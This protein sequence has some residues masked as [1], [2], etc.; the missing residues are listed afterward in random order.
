[1]ARGRKSVGERLDDLIGVF[2]PARAARRM[3]HRN[4][5]RMG[6]TYYK[7]ARQSRLS[8][9]WSTGQESADAAMD[10]EL[11]TLRDRSRDL[12]RNNPIAAGVTSTFTAN[13]VG[14]GIRPQSRVDVRDVPM[15]EDGARV[16]QR[17]AERVWERWSPWASAD[18]RMHIEE[19][20]D[21]ALR[22]IIESGEF[23]AVRRALATT[24]GRPYMLALNAIEPDRLDTPARTADRDI[25]F[26]VERNQD[27]Q[28]VAYHIRQTHPGDTLYTPGASYDYKRVPARDDA[29]RPIVFHVFPILRPG[30]TRGIPWF[31][32]VIEYFQHKADYMEAVIVKERVAACFAAFI[33][34]ESPY[35][36]A[37]GNA[38][39]TNSDNQRLEGL[40]PGMLEY[41]GP[42][43][44]VEFAKPPESGTSFAEFMQSL[45]RIIGAAL[46]LPY[47]LVIKDFSETSYSS[48]R[49]AL[50]QA[51]R[52]FRVWQRLLMRHLCQ[53]LWE[54][55]LEEAWLRGELEAPGWRRYRWH[56]TRALWLPPGWEWVDPLKEAKAA[57]LEVRM[58]H[59]TRA[60]VAAERGDDWEAK[61]EQAARERAVMEELGLP[62]EGMAKPG[63]AGGGAA[64]HTDEPGD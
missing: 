34:K 33:K 14:T 19:I 18:L 12:N 57:E 5:M 28:P 35:S 59:K 37:L 4:A 56:Y 53:P 50:L 10:G 62:W 13:V 31:A 47:E 2:S 64:A 54:L 8:Y 48:A 6:A 39:D 26:G 20:Q 30:Q 3:A 45:L 46:G 22:Q 29:G 32:P 11:Q 9:N 38:E 25:R 49:A 41:L 16:F 27:D 52:V 23:L 17:R 61:A 63:Q 36:A 24:Q 21:L 44:S 58:L 55:L 43:E 60:D 7:G 1:M 42:G 51:Y 40:E 15:D